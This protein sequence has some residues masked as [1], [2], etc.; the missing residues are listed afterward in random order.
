MVYRTIMFFQTRNVCVCM[1]L[2]LSVSVIVRRIDWKNQNFI[3]II[4]NH[5]PN[6]H[7]VNIIMFPGM[8]GGSFGF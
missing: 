8:K 5:K 6:D 3:K 7:S 4:K 1:C 2:R